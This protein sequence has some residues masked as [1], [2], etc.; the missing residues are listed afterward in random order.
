MNE[1]TLK[2]LVE[3]GA[4][5]RI[6]V[7]AD[8]AKFHVEV[9]TLKG[10]AAALTMKGTAKTWRSLDAAARWVRSL[11]IGSAQV[12]MARWQPDQIGLAIK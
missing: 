6:R 10:A 3:A 9:D 1:R 5:K 12:D 11:G 2:A 4:V 8:G 7:V